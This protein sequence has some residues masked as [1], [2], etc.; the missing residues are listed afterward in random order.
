MS[1]TPPGR[2]GGRY[3]LE[4]VVDSAT[5]ADVLPA[6]ANAHVLQSWAWGEFK[7]RWGWQAGRLLWREGEQPVAAAQVLR[8]SIP[9]TPWQ[10]LYVAKGPVL[11]YADAALA[12]TVLVDLERYA[13]Q[14]RALFIKIDPDVPRHFGEDSTLPPEPVG[15]QWLDRLAR[16]GW[17]FSPEQIQFRNT[18]LVDLQP[19]PEQ[20]LAAMKSKW[21][22]NIRLAERKGVII[23]SGPV[24]ELDYF[25]QMY[26]ETAA[27][28]GFLIRPEAYYQDGWRT[29]MA[30]GQAKL[31][32][33]EVEGEVVA[34]LLLFLCGS[35]AWY[36]YGAST[37]RQ[38]QLMPN[39]LL[40]WQAMV[41][42]KA[43]GC[44]YYDM[45]GAPDHFAES[46]RL[47]GVYRFK[48]GFGGQVRQGLGAYDFPLNRPLYWAFTQALP[49][50]RQLWRRVRQ[51][52]R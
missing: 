43:A 13:R 32:L 22:Y 4:R 19:A 37:G 44:R 46:D 8:R 17:H 14:G 47:W 28:D 10:F 16:R 38:R 26:A 23:R 21:R 51:L 7:S 15:Q 2:A 41:E 27:R 42:A 48:Q 29:F 36:L 31:L 1:E 18:V 9:G 12:E 25:F 33:A 24:A 20:L 49:R 6:L 50:L 11:D 35:T 45:W 52:D 40:Q 5:W 39:Y 3:R 34:G 30:L